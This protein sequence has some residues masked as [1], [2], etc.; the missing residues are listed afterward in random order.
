MSGL[1]VVGV[2]LGT[3]PLIISAVE[4]YERVIDTVRMLRRRA[5][6]MH[7]LARSL[8]TEQRILEN[9]CETLLGGIVPAD[10]VKPLLAEPFGPLW[11]DNKI[12]L[13][14]DRRLDHTAADFRDLVKAMVEALQYLRM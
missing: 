7:A 4:H 1:E 10:G 5:K 8:R 6:V 13:A 2:V 3:I 9:T 11:Q 12:Q 14:V